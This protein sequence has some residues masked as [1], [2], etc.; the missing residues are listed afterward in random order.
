MEQ[1]ISGVYS[2]DNWQEAFDKAIGGEGLKY[3][4]DLEAK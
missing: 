2:L 1:L 3:I 4:L